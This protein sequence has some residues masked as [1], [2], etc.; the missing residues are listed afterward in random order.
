MLMTPTRPTARPAPPDLPEPPLRPDR[1]DRLPRWAVAAGIAS[2]PLLIP[3]GPGNS[4]PA[5]MVIFFAIAVAL[6]WAASTRQRLRIPYVAGVSTM[7]A[8]G[9]LAAAFG[10][11]PHEAVL[12]LFQDFFLLAWGATIA[13]VA[14]TDM[15][16]RF[17]VRAWCVT[18]SLWG[19]GL[20]VFVGRT[21][22]T[23]GV[24]TADAARASFT[25][26]EQNGAG[27]YF[28]VT[29]FV[30]LAGRWP[31]R[32][33][34]RIPAIACLVFDTL[35]TGSLAAISGLVVG[36]GLALAV[37]TSARRGGAAGLVLLLAL[38]VSG[39]GIYEVMHHYQVV[40]R[41][42]SSQNLLLRNS[43]GRAQ[44]S[45]FERQTLAA[46]SAHLL[47]T[48]S[49][50][51]LGPAA[52]KSVLDQQQAPYPKEA[53]DD[54]TATL[55]ERGVLGLAGLLLL[56]AEVI[57]RA[58][59]VGSSRRLGTG[60]AAALP[61]SQYLVSALAVVAIYSFTHEILHDRTAWALFGILAAFS[62]WRGRVALSARAAGAT[63][64]TGGS[65]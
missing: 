22:A 53:H 63:M 48:S 52:T 37:R 5:D 38:A 64:T 16:A 62:L 9:A 29:V 25:L 11:F 26:G 7:V 43:I 13:N 32:L 36:L 61:A 65:R 46:E 55:V 30:I 33:R 40:E 59:K 31:R 57:V 12:T 47:S 41:A 45:T 14:R 17:L 50:L 10:G 56:V 28:V 58:T 21:A 6:L 4:A 2:L 49:L 19:I 44:Q 35:L 27:F 23:S 51:G 54:W 3:P 34:W 18:G 8:A 1:S 24:A 60:L 42:Q 39:G 20:L 15:A